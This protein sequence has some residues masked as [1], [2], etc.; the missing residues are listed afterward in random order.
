MELL[1]KDWLFWSIILAFVIMT[2]VGSE[3]LARRRRWS[4]SQG[5]EEIEIE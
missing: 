4:A 5:S 1:S 3:I 2:A